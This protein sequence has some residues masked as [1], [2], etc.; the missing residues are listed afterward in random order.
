MLRKKHRAGM[1]SHSRFSR[2][3]SILPALPLILFGLAAIVGLIGWTMLADRRSGVFEKVDPQNYHVS[4]YFPWETS[5]H[6]RPSVQIRDLQLGAYGKFF[7]WLGSLSW[8]L[9]VK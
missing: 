9:A 8:L 2:G 7:A 3:A 6:N 5:H 4:S 1:Q